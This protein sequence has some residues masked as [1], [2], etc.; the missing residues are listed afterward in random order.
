MPRQFL[1]SR[2]RHAQ[3]AEP[4]N[5]SVPQRV[6]TNA[7]KFQAI[8]SPL[9]AMGYGVARDV[10]VFPREDVRALVPVEQLRKDCQSHRIEAHRLDFFGLGVDQANKLPFQVHVLAQQAELLGPAEAGVESQS[11]RQEK[12]P[13]QS[14]SAYSTPL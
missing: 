10:A 5:E 12:V 1:D 8:A 9:K 3:H 14:L 4:G 13:R 2:Q 6:P 11:N 7:L